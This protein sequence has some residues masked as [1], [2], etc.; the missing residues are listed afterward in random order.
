MWKMACAVGDNTTRVEISATHNNCT[1][2]KCTNE[3]MQF[4]TQLQSHE[5]IIK[6]SLPSIAQ[7]ADADGQVTRSLVKT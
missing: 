5:T 2:F 7:F 3:S 6:N 1:A 4:G